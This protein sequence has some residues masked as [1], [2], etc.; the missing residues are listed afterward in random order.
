MTKNLTAGVI[1]GYLR[2]MKLR[3]AE[4]RSDI[5]QQLN[6]FS[7][8]DRCGMS[9]K[10]RL[11]KEEVVGLEARTSCNNFMCDNT[12]R[13]SCNNFMCACC[14]LNVD[15]SMSV[16][17]NVNEGVIDEGVIGHVSASRSTHTGGIDPQAASASQ[18]QL[19]LHTGALTP[20]ESQVGVSSHI[21]GPWSGRG[22][23][24]KGLS[25]KDVWSSRGDDGRWLR[26]HRRTRQALFTPMRV[27]NG[28]SI[29]AQLVRIRR[30]TG[31]DFSTLRNFEI[32]DDWTLGPLF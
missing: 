6:S 23:P 13:I 14:C 12:A 29:D 25:E 10:G 21:G 7:G 20:W 1:R 5:A 4:G 17:C 8:A 26:D 24:V 18:A 11:E 32:I 19:S 2:K 3:Y 22:G 27:A 30:T 9:R 28:P 31:S 16:R 15:G